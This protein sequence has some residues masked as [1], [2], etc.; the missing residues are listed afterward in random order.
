MLVLGLIAVIIGGET[1][2][3]SAQTIAINWGISETLVGLTIVSLGTSLP[4]LVTSIMAVKK[5]ETDI[6]IGN[7]IGSNIFNILFVIGL[8]SSVAS[9][10]VNYQS[11]I[12]II[13]LLGVSIMCYIFTFFNSRIGNKKGFIMVITYIAFMIYIIIR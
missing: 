9:L 7:V 13:I 1:V 4:E 3:K 10:P 8:S 11:L 2:V 6:A 5:G 12:D